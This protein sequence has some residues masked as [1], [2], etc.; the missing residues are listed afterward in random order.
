MRQHK[1][2]AYDLAH[3]KSVTAV[4]LMFEGKQ[5]GKIVANWSD[6]P[7]GSVCTATVSIWDGPLKELPK[8]TASAGGYGYDKLSACLSELL[9][10]CPDSGRSS[11]YQWL[12]KQG[13]GVMEVC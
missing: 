13:Y 1:R 8:S 11:C 10:G 5:A 9:D 3:V 7:A 2:T 6:N 12:E 4:A